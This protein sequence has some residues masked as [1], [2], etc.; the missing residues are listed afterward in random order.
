MPQTPQ[1]LRELA[2]EKIVEKVSSVKNLTSITLFGSV[3]RGGAD[4]RS[5]IDLL[6][7]FDVKHDPEKGKEDKDIRK[8]ISEIEKEL[9]PMM[10]EREELRI[11][12]TLA[13]MDKIIETELYKKISREG[14]LVWGVP[15]TVKAQELNLDPY[16]IFSYSLE[17]LKQDEKGRVNRALSGR[18]TERAY[19]GKKYI[20]EQK[21][22]IA[23]YSGTKLG[24]GVVLVPEKNTKPFKE[25]F[26]RFDVDY[27]EYNIWM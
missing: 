8:I 27:K 12:P 5:D 26:R 6:F 19:R 1:K 23:E 20:S 14:K 2:V 21:G 16:V 13:R 11:Q 15:F 17:K 9:L 10:D 22:L 24:H 7:V 18:K 4:R 3:A 25:L